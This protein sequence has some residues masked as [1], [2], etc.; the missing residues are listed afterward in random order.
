MEVGP[1]LDIENVDKIGKC[2][3]EEILGVS[4]SINKDSE[5][6]RIFEVVRGQ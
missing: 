2:G 1:E 3:W 5:A 6:R 4:N